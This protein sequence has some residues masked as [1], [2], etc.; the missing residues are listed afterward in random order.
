MHNRLRARLSNPSFTCHCLHRQLWVN[1]KTSA[2]TDFVKRAL[3]PAPSC[4]LCHST[5]VV[6]ACN[7][8]RACAYNRGCEWYVQISA[9]GSLQRAIDSSAWGYQGTWCV[10]ASLQAV[11]FRSSLLSEKDAG[12]ELKRCDALPQ[13]KVIRWRILLPRIRAPL[14]TSRLY[15]NR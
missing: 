13:T 8:P 15:S 7:S 5:A 2:S 11:P 14:R 4:T 3:S 1:S 12:A 9:G 10:I 6:S